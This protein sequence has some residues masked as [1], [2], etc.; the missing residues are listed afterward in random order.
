M[1]IVKNIKYNMFKIWYSFE[2][3][4]I[5]Q[6]QVKIFIIFITIWLLLFLLWYYFHSVTF[7]K[8]THMLPHLWATLVEIWFAVLVVDWFL[9]MKKNEKIKQDVFL[10]EKKFYQLIKDDFNDIL[11]WIE[12][13]KSDFEESVVSNVNGFLENENELSPM[14]LYSRPYNYNEFDDKEFSDFEECVDFILENNIDSKIDFSIKW[15]VL[16]SLNDI[17]YNM[18]K[19]VSYANNS[20]YKIS[21]KNNSYESFLKLYSNI[22]FLYVNNKNWLY[23]HNFFT[24]IDN[25]NSEFELFKISNKADSKYYNE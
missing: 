14:E 8:Y 19:M 22:R 11:R 21:F 6:V 9:E 2:K 13:F 10:R 23:W 18:D 17:Y 1:Y 15:D 3:W 5:G 12:K 20:F 25:L 16:K 4:F 7:F 24:M